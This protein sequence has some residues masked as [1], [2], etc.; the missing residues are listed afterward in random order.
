MHFA[1]LC[2]SQ[3]YILD[4]ATAEALAAWKMVRFCISMGW[5]SVWLEAGTE[6]GS[7]IGGTKA[8]FYFFANV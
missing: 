2:A 3:R 8:I 4:P 7:F 6:P 5:D 1:G